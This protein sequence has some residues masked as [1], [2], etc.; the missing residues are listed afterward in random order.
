MLT[1]LHYHNVSNDYAK[2]ANTNL[3]Y[4]CNIV[5]S[6]ILPAVKLQETHQFVACFLP[7][8]SDIY[9]YLPKMFDV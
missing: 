2:P 7:L 9:L 5:F 8:S 1:M 3:P 4:I 6:S